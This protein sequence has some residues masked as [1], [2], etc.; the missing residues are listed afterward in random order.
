LHRRALGVGRFDLTPLTHEL[1][2]GW[3]EYVPKREMLRESENV[4]PFGNSEKPSNVA[5]QP[6]MGKP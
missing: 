3:H 2:N 5:G 4:N 1:V 6:A